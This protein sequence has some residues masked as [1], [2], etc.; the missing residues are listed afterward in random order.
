MSKFNLNQLL[1]ATGSGNNRSENQIY[2]ISFVPIHDLEPSSDNFYS[3]EQIKELKESLAAFGIKQNLVVKQLENGKYRVIAGHR[4]RLAALSLLEEGNKEFEK[5]P[6]MIETEE[7]ELRERLLLITTNSTARQLSDW[8]KIQQ[9]KEMKSILEQIKKRDKI[10][11]RLRDLIASVLDTSPTQ[12]GRMEAIDKNL[13]SEF[14]DE[15][16]EGKVN[17]ST[18]YELSGMPIE[19][20]QEAYAEYQ[21]KGSLSIKEVKVKKVITATETMLSVPVTSEETNIVEAGNEKILEKYEC[22][23][24]DKQ[25]L[26]N[27]ASSNRKDLFCPY[28]GNP[29][30]SIAECAS[31]VAEELEDMMGCL[32]VRK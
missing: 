4:R 11:G 10:P 1:G 23:K 21:D 12:V 18:A 25:F 26:T 24:C 31:E 29:A 17:L 13:S 5:V 16:K 14:K 6:C 28:C 30:E 22:L 32:F 27:K 20:Q 7:D 9:A 2:K 3:V 19:Q 8:E 15:L